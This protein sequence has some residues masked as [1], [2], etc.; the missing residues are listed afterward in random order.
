MTSA[1]TPEDNQ[2]LISTAVVGE[3]TQT[4][5]VTTNLQ[6]NTM[7]ILEDK[8]R[9]CL[10]NHVKRV[11]A[12]QGWI[13]PLTTLI[14]LVATLVTTDFKDMVFK[15]EVWQALFVMCAGACVIWLAR[16][17]LAAIRSAGVEDIIEELKSPSGV[18]R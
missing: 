11:E 7:V 13:A 15:K 10:M 6:S 18:R 1:S 17:G 2:R 3:L 16:T 9:L 5:T 14:A 8:L 4:I 12:R